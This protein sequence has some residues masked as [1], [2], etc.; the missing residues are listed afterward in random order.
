MEGER[1]EREREEKEGQVEGERAGEREE[2]EEQVE[3]EEGKEEEEKK[4]EEKAEERDAAYDGSVHTPTGG[5]VWEGVEEET[6]DG[7]ISLSTSVSLPLSSE[8]DG[9]SEEDTVGQIQALPTATPTEVLDSL[10]LDMSDVFGE[11]VARRGEGVS[12]DGEGVA[13]GEGKLF[14]LS[15]KVRVEGEDV[16]EEVEGGSRERVGR[17]M[18]DLSSQSTDSTD[19]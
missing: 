11:G 9:Q 3:A 14:M 19:H 10:V 5:G 15:D 17:E 7:E 12:G 13:G 2:E 16:G 4:E 8:T 18:G 6:V 1:E